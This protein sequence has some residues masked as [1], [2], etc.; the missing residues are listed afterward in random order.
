MFDSENIPVV[1]TVEA[2]TGVVVTYS[3]NS[4]GFGQFKAEVDTTWL[5]EQID[6]R[7]ASLQAD[8]I[9]RLEILE[10]ILG[11]TT[12]ASGGG[13]TTTPTNQVII[14]GATTGKYPTGGTI[15][16]TW[17]IVGIDG[18]NIVTRSYSQVIPANATP[19]HVA[20]ALTTALTN[21]TA[22]MKYLTSVTTDVTG[23]VNF[24]WKQADAG[25]AISITGVTGPATFTVN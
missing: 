6:A 24:A 3:V 25:F 10:K 23:K 22:A 12:A 14:G 11:V 1:T 4:A 9:G 21:S 13:S 15:A 2:G 8:Y 5:E 17:N 16:L 19:G 18:R 7:Y 20:A